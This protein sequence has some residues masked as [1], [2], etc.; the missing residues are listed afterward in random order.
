MKVMLG[1]MELRNT[2]K[3]EIVQQGGGQMLAVNQFPGGNVSIQNFGSTYRD[4]SWNGWFEGSDAMDRMYQIGNMRQKGLPVLLI[5]ENYTANVVISEFHADHR[6]NFFI[7]FSIVLKRVIQITKEVSKEAVDKASE[8][9][10]E[11]L[12]KD[13]GGLSDST[14][15]VASIKSYQIK[16]GDTLSKIAKNVYGNANDWDKIYQTNKD[17]LTNG[18]HKLGVG[19]EL[20]L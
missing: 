3:P 18:P 10:T 20:K 8:K 12:V 15:T 4:I 9:I 6:T 7:P 13:S 17:I 19:Q 1:D 5:T 2:E 16:S 11:R 14:I